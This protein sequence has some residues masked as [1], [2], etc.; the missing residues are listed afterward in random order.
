MFDHQYQINLTLTD[1]E[2]AN[3]LYWAALDAQ[4]S[5]PGKTVFGVI[6]ES[7]LDQRKQMI[8]TEL[9]KRCSTGVRES[10][11]IATRS[12]RTFVTIFK[13]AV[14]SDMAEAEDFLL[15]NYFRSSDSDNNHWSRS[16]WI[17]NV[18]RT[19]VDRTVKI[20]FE[21]VA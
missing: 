11:A 19:S 4:K 15:N 14:F 6:S 10:Y 18:I 2:A 13:D 3:M 16:D 5:Q 9:L 12:Y 8:A 21:M 7:T 20:I 17:A 1:D